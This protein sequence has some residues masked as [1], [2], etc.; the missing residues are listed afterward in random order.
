MDTRSNRQ[1]YTSHRLASKLKQ[2][3]SHSGTSG[4]PAGSRKR[5]AIRK[6]A[7]ML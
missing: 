4:D 5:D 6:A 1:E 7:K 2:Q 3:T